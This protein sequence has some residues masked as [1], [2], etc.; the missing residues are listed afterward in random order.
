M[1]PH[2]NIDI[3]VKVVSELKKTYPNPK[4]IITARGFHHNK[5]PEYLWKIDSMIHEQ[6]LD[7]NIMI[8]QDELTSGTND[9]LVLKDFYKL[10]DAVFY[11]SSYENFGLPI[12]EAGLSKNVIIC[13]DLQVFKEIS[14]QNI[15]ST[16]ISRPPY[17]IAAFVNEVLES[18]KSNNLFRTVKSKYSLEAV[19]DSQILPFISQIMGQGPVPTV[20][21]ASRV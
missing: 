2:K 4:L 6:E 13:S 17:E 9:L 12:L 19:F 21:A 11:F 14:P 5:D 3:A 8:I 18:Q 15:F 20:S 16:N 10:C 7:K 1:M